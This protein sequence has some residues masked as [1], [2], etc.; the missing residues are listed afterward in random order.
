MNASALSTLVRSARSC[1]RFV[2][3]DPI[4]E[5]L[6]LEFVDTARLAPSSRNQQALRFLIVSA[7]QERERVFPYLKWAAALDWKGPAQGER[8]TGYILLL[9]PVTTHTAHDAGI[10]AMT[11]KLAAAAA[12]Y[13]SC[14]LGG[15]DRPG[16][17]REL[18]LPA[19][20]EID[21][22]LALGRAG[23]TV[24]IEQLQPGASQN[25]WRDSSSVHHVPKR[26][27]SELLYTLPSR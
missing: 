19:D 25:Y 20:I 5:A 6:L 16:L 24:S 17:H 23:E 13:A 14:M 7:P 4:P 2:E 3:A 27:L 26:A 12:G 22:A 21:I 18:N 15:L 9:K 1:R 11:I 10:A 8:A